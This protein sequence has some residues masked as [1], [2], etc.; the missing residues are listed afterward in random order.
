M[1]GGTPEV[2]SDKRLTLLT[3]NIYKVRSNG[4]MVQLDQWTNGPLEQSTNDPMVQWTHGP[5]FN[6][7]LYSN[8]QIGWDWPKIPGMGYITSTG[9]PVLDFLFF[10]PLDSIG[11]L[12]HCL[13]VICRM[14]KI[15]C[16]IS[17]RL[18]FCR[19][20]PLKLLRSFLL[21][22]EHSISGWLG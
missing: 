16:Q 4:P 17:I 13:N 14:S 3:F 11:P 19:S 15:K 9:I 22:P 10:P 8:L 6:A 12:V 1:T 2:R 18:N 21:S 7:M 20:V 5:H